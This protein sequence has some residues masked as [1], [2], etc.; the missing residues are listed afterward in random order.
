MKVNQSTTS[1]ILSEES[2][3]AGASMGTGHNRSRPSS[4]PDL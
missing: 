2:E 4:A 1:D 3:V